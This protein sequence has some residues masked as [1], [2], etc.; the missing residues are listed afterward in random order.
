MEKVIIYG[1]GAKFYQYDLQKCFEKYEIIALCDGDVTKQGQI[2]LEKEIISPNDIKNYNYDKIVITSELHY[3]EIKKYLISKDINEEKIILLQSYTDKYCG[4]LGYWKQQ[5]VMEKGI[6]QNEHYRKI[7]LGIAQENSDEFLSGKIVADF[8]CGPRG[9]LAW[10]KVPAIKIGIDVLADKYFEE[11]GECLATHN[12]IYVKSTEKKISLPTNYVDYLY[13]I[14]SLD[15]VDNLADMATE[16][17]R[18]IKPGG[19]LLGS[20]N[21]NEVASECEPQ[22]LT[23]EIL[24]GTL[25]NEFEIEMMKLAYKDEKQAYYNMQKEIFID[26]IKDMDPE[27][28]AVLWVKGRKNFE[29]KRNL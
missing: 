11:F 2:V 6:F 28:P 29:N 27:K 16:I 25:L 4:E 23:M 8:G 12:T 14:N 1:I 3:G 5:Y 26:D 15:H 18:I 13:T 24:Q 9:S 17:L 10:T 20:F 22:R 21:L 19:Y 7:M